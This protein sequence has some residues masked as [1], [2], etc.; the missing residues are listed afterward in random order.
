M[1]IEKCTS[2]DVSKIKEYIGNEYYKCLYLYIDL[3]QYGIDNSD[4]KVWMQVDENNCIKAVFL[5]Y[6]TALHIYS[7]DH[8]FEVHSTLNL[9]KNISPSMICA[10]RSIIEKLSFFMLPW[11]YQSEFGYIGKMVEFNN[12]AVN[13][14]INKATEKDIDAIAILLYEDEDIGASYTINDLKLQIKERLSDGFVRSYVIKDNGKVVAHLGTGAETDKICTINYLIVKPSY[15]NKGLASQLF[16]YVCNQLLLEGKE[17]Y[18]VYYME[19]AR[20]LHHRMG[21][22][23]I[24]DFG[25]IYLQQ[26]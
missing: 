17:I 7:K 1:I 20:Y 12:M 18:S 10:E 13:V 15:R 2:Y 26:H 19:N 21:F 11:G 5:K 14:D 4:V 25:K 23:D 3:L 22:V 8:D 9:I 16:L 6:H 24:C